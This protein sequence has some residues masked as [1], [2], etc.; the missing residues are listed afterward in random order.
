MKYGCRQSTGMAE[1]EAWRD[2][3]SRQLVLGSIG[4][5]GQRRLGDVTAVVVGAGGLGSNSTELLVR[6]GLG[7]VR[8]VDHDLLELSNLHRVRL[9]GEEDVGRPKVD[10]LMDHL[11]TVAD[12][13]R[14]ETRRER[15][16]PGNALQLLAGAD[17]VLDGLDNMGSRYILNDACLEMGVPWIYGGVVA[18]GGLVAPFLPGGPC[19]RCL[20]PVPDDR[21][22]LPTTSTHGI[23]PSLPSV[24]ASIQV[25]MA[26]RVVLEG[27][28][29]PALT[30][31]D[32]WSDDWRVVTLSKR[33]DCPACS[34][35]RRDYLE[36]SS[37]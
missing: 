5:E 25:A 19:L 26:T 31:M 33:A 24:V 22:V 18:T 7:C 6:M 8:V 23:H 20:F 2:R 34:F 35:G 29:E 13:T 3:F 14:I 37:F 12:E 28:P 30:A 15:L 27:I 21:D 36:G 1:E 11:T 10:A 17:V 4:E 32:L 16:G 9:Y